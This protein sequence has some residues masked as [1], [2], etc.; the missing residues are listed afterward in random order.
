MQKTADTKLGFFNG[1]DEV[2][3]YF[4][5]LMNIDINDEQMKDILD[6]KLSIRTPLSMT[7][8]IFF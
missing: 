8:M 7:S 5:E 1:I 3:K 6:S 4:A 2:N